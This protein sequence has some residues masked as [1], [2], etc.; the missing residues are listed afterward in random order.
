[1]RIHVRIY[2]VGWQVRPLPINLLADCFAVTPDRYSRPANP[3]SPLTEGVPMRR[4]LPSTYD[5]RQLQLGI[6]LLW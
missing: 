1:M 5:P 4:F 2:D 6:E 3:R